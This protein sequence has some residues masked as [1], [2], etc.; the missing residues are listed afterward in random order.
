MVDSDFGLDGG[1]KQFILEMI[2][3]L[4]RLNSVDSSI[5]LNEL[6][7]SRY[8]IYPHNTPSDNRLLP[9]VAMN[10]S[11]DINKGSLLEDA[12]KSFVFRNIKDTFGLDILDY[13]NLPMDVCEILTD[14]SIEALKSKNS[15]MENIEGEFNKLDK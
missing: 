8:G 12:V 15:Q 9:G 4:A 11:E 14:V 1:A 2:P 5:V 10:L 13:L 3:K 6:Y 7:E